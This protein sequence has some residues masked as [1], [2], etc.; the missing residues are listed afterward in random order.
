MPG[1]RYTQTVEKAYHIS[2][3]CFQL[4]KDAKEPKRADVLLHQ[5]SA[6]FLLC[7]LNNQKSMTT[8]DLMFTEGEQV[9]F[10]L[11][12]DGPVHLT[13]Y[14]MDFGDDELSD[15]D[16]DLSDLVEEDEEE[17]APVAKEIAVKRK[18]EGS[19]VEAKKLKVDDKTAKAAT[20]VAK[21]NGNAVAKTANAAADSDEEDDEELG[22]LD[23]E[24]DD[25]EE[26]SDEEEDEEDDEEEE[27]DEEEG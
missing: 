22:L 13:G 21:V 27:E 7:S 2:K 1:R 6:K 5:D 11:E 20:P 4:P 23:E 3:A 12:G 24:D 17:E 15:V 8:L 18:P 10:S 19:P 16:S 14:L 9:T 25:D 26:L